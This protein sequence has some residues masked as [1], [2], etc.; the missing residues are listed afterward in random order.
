MSNYTAT[1]ALASI[2]FY[3]EN[4]KKFEMRAKPK[5]LLQ[6]F[7]QYNDMV[8][9]GINEI[10]NAPTRTNSTIYLTHAASNAGTSKSYSHSGTVGDSALVNLGWYTRTEKFKISLKMADYQYF[11]FNEMFTNRLIS[12]MNNLQ[13]TVEGVILTY[14]STNKSQ[15]VKSL[16]PSNVSWNGSTYVA[17]NAKGNEALY[18]HNIKSFMRQQWHNAPYDMVADPFIYAMIEYYANQ[19]NMNATNTGFQTAGVDV[20]ETVDS[21]SLGASYN[22]G[23]YIMPKYS[24]GMPTFNEMANR[25]NKKAGIY[26][27]TTIPDLTG[28]PIIYDLHS[29]TSGADNQST[30]GQRQDVDTEYELSLTFA[31]TLAPLSTSNESPVFL[32]GQL[33]S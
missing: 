3:S 32:T 25:E 5:P 14:M 29:Y 8:F 33:N 6:A 31:P 20:L 30:Y 11:N 24:Y 7:L 17:A 2:H 22:G 19:G 10:K 1:Q 13:A 21:L 28:L 9:P 26:E 12:A 18:L 4:A 16:T 15:V 27:Y 23:A